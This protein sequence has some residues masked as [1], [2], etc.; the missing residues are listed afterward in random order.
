MMNSAI[1]T[2]MNKECDNRQYDKA[3]E[4]ENINYTQRCT[5][6]E[7]IFEQN[8]KENIFVCIAM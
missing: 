8:K 7:C 1:I 5:D 2:K 3:Y 6:V 4:D